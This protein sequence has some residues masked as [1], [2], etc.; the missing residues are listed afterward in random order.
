MAAGRDAAPRGSKRE[1][2]TFLVADSNAHDP[3]LA[4]LF[5]ASAGPV[6]PPPKSR[7]QAPPPTKP[8]KA[9][10]ENETPTDEELSELEDAEEADSDAEIAA[11]DSSLNAQ[12]AVH[13][14]QALTDEGQSSKTHKKRKRRNEE[15]DNLEGL[16]LQ[17]L[18]REEA[19][20]VEVAQRAT[21][22]RKPENGEDEDGSSDASEQTSEAED[23]DEDGAEAA[24]SD[25][26]STY[27]IPQ[28][29]SL[30]PNKDASELEKSSRTVFL[31]NV[32]TTAITSKSAR[33][34]LLAHLSSFL[35]SLP[36]PANSPPHKVESL[37]FRSTAFATPIPKKAAFAKKELMEATTKSTNAYAV[38]STQAAAREA[39][40]RLNGSVVLDRHLRVDEVAHPAKVDHRRCVFVGNLGFVDDSSAIDAAKDA[41]SGKKER[42][43]TKPPGDVEEGLWR[44]LSKAGTVESVRVIRDAKTR[45]GKGIAYD[46]NGAEAALLYNDKSFPPLLPRKLRVLRAKAQKRNAAKIRPPPPRHAANGIYNPKPQPEHASLA[47]RAGKLLGRAGAAQVLKGQQRPESG[48]GIGIGAGIRAP[49]GFVFEGHRASSKQ[50]K[51]GLKL[52]GAGK[53]KGK[54]KGKPTTRSS[55]RGEAWK[56]QGGKK[57]GK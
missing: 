53:K 47:G 31:G 11:E 13:A 29:E 16:Y 44:Q 2:K 3:A 51:S 7:Y 1:A 55:R 45:V 33:K 26:E 20:E 30:N 28:H 12:D 6:K 37:R 39:A 8:S 14:P 22:R 41:E 17:N 54:G 25:L 50:G 35:P 24:D 18:A 48:K 10:A 36:V 21:K 56:A 52:G 15:D 9:E 57:G 49:E 32:S 42:K 43:K 19:K 5:A 4:S 46:E 34:T 27:S 38:Y 40:K 23:A